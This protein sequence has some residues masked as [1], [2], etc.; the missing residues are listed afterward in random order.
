MTTGFELSRSGLT[1]PT[2]ATAFDTHV[3]LANN[4]LVQFSGFGI[5]CFYVHEDTA[6]C[7]ILR[8]LYPP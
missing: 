6:R 8:Y 5:S 7:M 3:T 4:L 1:M 2:G